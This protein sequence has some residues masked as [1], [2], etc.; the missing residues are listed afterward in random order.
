M[1]SNAMCPEGAPESGT[2]YRNHIIRERSV[3]LAPL[4][5]RIPG[6]RV[7]RVETLAEI[8]SP[9][10]GEIRFHHQFTLYQIAELDFQAEKLLRHFQYHLD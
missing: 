3:I 6:S 10:R 9:F 5:G 2:P 7:P 1:H 8:F 4:S